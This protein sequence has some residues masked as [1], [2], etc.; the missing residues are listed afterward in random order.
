MKR[1]TIKRL[2]LHS[3]TALGLLSQSALA[4]L[5]IEDLFQHESMP[6]RKQT[7]IV[8]ISDAQIPYT[9]EGKVHFV[10]AETGKYLGALNTGYWYGGVVLPKT[11]NEIISPETYF[12]RGT[13]GKRT[14]IVA[15][16]DPETLQPTGEVIIPSKRMTPVKV[17]GATALTDDERFLAVMNVTPATSIS[18]VDVE[19]RE[20]ITEIE[21][22]GCTYVYANGVRRF[23][24]ICADGSFMNIELDD[25]GQLAT[26]SRR[27][28]VFDPQTDPLTNDAYRMGN[29]W[30]QLSMNGHVH[31]FSN[32]PDGSI[33]SATW[34]LL[35]DE[36]R[37]DNWRIA[38][39]QRMTIHEDSQRL[40]VLMI[41]GAPELFEDP[42]DQVWVYDLK[43]QK[44]IDTFELERP[45][46][47]INIAQ[48]DN[49][50]FYAVAVDLQMPLVLSALVYLLEDMD[51]MMR[52][53]TMSFDIYDL[54][55]GELQHA[56]PK[57]GNFPNLI[58]PWQ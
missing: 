49:P 6:D 45:A 3:L 17:Q 40:Y 10:N 44:R 35:T 47:W 41:Q 11:R 33:S 37:E 12:E 27:A 15:F 52:M 56:L 50:K 8:T 38:G 32:E 4:T 34:S 30:Y 23:N 54:S 28:A 25:E 26:R 7:Q 57:I 14:D 13:R 9:S 5:P 16:Y 46:L 1:T 43:T 29:A 58:Q 39:H 31:H 53:S 48:G 24:L 19:K 55:N 21:T 36:E 22:P 2:W 42:S 51:H 18:I 20:F